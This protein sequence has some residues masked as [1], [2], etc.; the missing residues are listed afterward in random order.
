MTIVEGNLGPVQSCGQARLLVEVPLASIHPSRAGV[1]VY[2]QM[3]QFLDLRD[4]PQALTAILVVLRGAGDLDFNVTPHIC[5]LVVHIR[6]QDR[7]SALL[8]WTYA[9]SVRLL[10]T[11]LVQI[12][13]VLFPAVFSATLVLT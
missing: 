1:V 4:F 2:I 12:S 6:L 3:I 5:I 9:L 8:G 7:S 11:F 13:A 10:R